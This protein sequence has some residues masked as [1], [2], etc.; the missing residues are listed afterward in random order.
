L[1]ATW[2]KLEGYAARLALIVH[3]I[4]WAAG[5]P[6]LGDAD[7]VDERSVKAGV[8]LST[9]FGHEAR[10]VYGILG[11]DPEQ[12]EHRRLV[13]MIQS[14]EGAVTTREVQRSSRKYANAKDAE[15]ALETLVE[16]GV[17][18][19]EDPK[20]GPAGGRPVRRFVLTQCVDADKTCRD[21]P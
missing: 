9:W 4:R 8:G 15:Q 6:T 10:R 20:P 16:A 19:W 18:V 12:R 13:E 17:G 7:V 11:E 1:A 21:G 3:L 14:R 2:S 5:D